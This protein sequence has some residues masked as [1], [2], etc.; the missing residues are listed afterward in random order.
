MEGVVSAELKEKVRR[1]EE[2]KAEIEA[3]TAELNQYKG[4]VGLDD[5]TIRRCV[6]NVAKVDIDTPEGLK[7]ILAVVSRVNIHTDTIEIKTLISMDGTDP[8]PT[9]SR[10]QHL[11]LFPSESASGEKY[12]TTPENGSGHQMKTALYSQKRLYS[13]VFYAFKM[14]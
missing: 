3:E 11:E 14:L 5:A 13:A 9:K 10:P 12:H 8:D 1:L 6:E 7:L 4:Y 2:E